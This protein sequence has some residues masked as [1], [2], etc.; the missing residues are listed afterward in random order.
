MQNGRNFSISTRDGEAGR[1][2]AV[3]ADEYRQDAEFVNNLVQEF[4]STSGELLASIREVI[5]TIEH[6][7]V[8]SNE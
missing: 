4:S 6:V 1:S 3:V 8:A 2:F 5:K 7:S